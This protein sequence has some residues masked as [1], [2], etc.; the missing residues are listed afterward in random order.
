L[1]VAK[2]VNFEILVFPVEGDKDTKA[3]EVETITFEPKLKTFEMDVMEAMGIQ[4]DRIPKKTY[5]Y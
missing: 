3:K 4:E 5:W 1:V 2:S